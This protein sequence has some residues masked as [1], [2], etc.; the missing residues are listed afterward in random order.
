MEG[1][2]VKTVEK[3]VWLKHGS[4]QVRVETLTFRIQDS[5]EHLRQK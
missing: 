5:Q 4:F 2:M 3:G 1:E